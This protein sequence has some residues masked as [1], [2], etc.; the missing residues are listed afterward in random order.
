LNISKENEL[1]KMVF[2]DQ[3]ADRGLHPVM[4]LSLSVGLISYYITTL[5][6]L[7]RLCVVEY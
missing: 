1:Q 3:M 5:F 2:V 6:Q 7:F 4:D